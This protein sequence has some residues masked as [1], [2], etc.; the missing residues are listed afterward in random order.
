MVKLFPAE[1][2]G[3]AYAKSLK[4][5]FP[6]VEL[7]ATG[8]VSLKTLRNYLEAGVEG[9]GLG[10]SICTRERVDAGD[11][12]WMTEQVRKHREIYEAFNGS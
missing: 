11:W 9:F 1:L 12:E 4:G 10:S 2:G 7:I 6:D 5:P 8:G 3:P